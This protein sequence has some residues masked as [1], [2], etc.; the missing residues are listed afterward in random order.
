MASAMTIGKAISM[1]RSAIVNSRIYP[2]GSQMVE[3]SLKGAYEALV[4]CLGDGAPI[5]ISDIH[6][7]M[8]ANGK[9]ISEARDFRPFLV[10]HEIQSL[11]FHKDV[12]LTDIALLL[13][14]LAQKK[15]QLEGGV[16]HFGEWLKSKGVT[17][18]E[19]EEI[20][21]VELKKGDV[22]IQQVYSLLEQASGDPAGLAG[23]LEES[24]RMVDQLP[25]ETS[26]TE[27]RKRMAGHIATLPP[28]Q[29]RDLFDSKLPEQIENSTL[30]TDVIQALSRDKLEET[31]EEVHKW[32]KQIKQDSKSELEAVE[33]LNGLKSFLG[34]VLH[35]P[36]SKTVPF[37]L[38]EELLQVN[39]IEQVPVGVQ[40]GE[41]SGLMAEI[42]SL[43]SR[44][45]ESLTEQSVRQRLPDLL[46]ALCA[47]KLDDHV[48][49]LTDKMLENL[50]NPAPIV[51]AAAAKMIKV[52]AELLAANRKDKAFHLVAENLHTMAESESAPDVY[53]EIVTGLQV[54][55][56]ELMVS[57]RFEESSVLLATL[58]RHIRDDSPI[59]TKKKGHAAKALREF[60]SR[61]LETICADLNAVVKERQNGAL[62]VLAELG[63]EAVAPL[64][65]AVKKSIDP[66][67]R[68]AALQA[69]RRLGPSVKEALLKQLHLGVSGEALVKLIPLLEEFA[70]VSLLPVATQL[71]QHPDA[72]VRR[73][74]AQLLGK[75]KEP[76]VQ[77]LL[78]NLLDD[79][80]I[81]VQIEAVRL[82][83]D[84]RLKTAAIELAK[85]LSGAAPVVQEDMCIALGN[86]AEKRAISDLIPIVHPTKS[87]WKKGASVSDAVRVRAIWALGQLLPDEAA[88][89]AL[90]KELKDPN[91]LILRAAQ[92][93]INRPVAAALAQITPVS[94]AA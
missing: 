81:E 75:I 89:K 16:K 60:A 69:L 88:K 53:E 45:S 94:K 23:A 17:K 14:G 13:D 92:S 29:I 26:K 3:A 79:A 67:A 28:S 41:N 83:G 42:E 65:E 72:A 63:E 62:R 78:T 43:L 40:K 10:Q 32:Y 30:K 8:C 82:I 90:V 44:P 39:L 34:K 24:Y 2:K 58:R 6:G 84:L 57:W 51:R 55:A 56:M 11:K 21:F 7:K 9:E 46:K 33:K 80:D 91:P 15:G 4:T 74:V 27:V 31:L 71:L 22:V 19:C 76:K 61:G 87:F 5:I 68:Q 85:R 54:A 20:E 59:G 70:D 49:R 77:N 73:Q 50:H 64:V 66:R 35:S 48:I 1:L 47:M 52:F 18:I 38:Y 25:D 93:A 86:L 36:Q 37:A 12:T